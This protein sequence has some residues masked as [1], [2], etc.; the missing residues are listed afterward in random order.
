MSRYTIR[1][2]IGQPNPW[3]GAKGGPMLGYSLDVTGD[4]G[5]A[6]QVELNQKVD[7]P[8]PTV[9]QVI[10]GTLDKSNP[11]YAPK[12]KKAQQSFAGSFSGPG[13]GKSK[14]DQDSI[15]RAVAYKGAVDLVAA[16]ITKDTTNTMVKSALT[17]LFDYSLELL[18]GGAGS[19]GPAKGMNRAIA[20][21]ELYET[22]SQAEVKDIIKEAFP[23]AEEIAPSNEELTS[24]YNKWVVIEEA[25]SSA[26]QARKL[27]ETKK[28]ALGIVGVTGNATPAQKRELLDWFNS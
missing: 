6:G 28:T 23:D 2:I 12:L 16:W 25:R 27:L 18:Q 22:D 1:E 20:T 3:Q 5:F 7:T 19:N 13:K 10:E 17:E 15:E 8:A 4:D 11:K 21:G 26:E 9:G 24:A 14:A